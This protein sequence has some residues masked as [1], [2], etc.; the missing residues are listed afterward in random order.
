MQCV[1]YALSS[2]LLREIQDQ[3][4]HLRYVCLCLPGDEGIEAIHTGRENEGTEDTDG[5]DETRGNKIF[6]TY[7]QEN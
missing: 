2:P 1:M 7:A 3:E 6:S 5:C 4:L